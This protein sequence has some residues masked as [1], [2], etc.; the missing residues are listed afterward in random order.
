MNKL[1]INTA[2]DKLFIVLQKEN[3]LFYICNMAKMHHNETMLL[4]IDQL[5]QENNIS[6]KQIDELGVVIGPGS[7]TGIRVG[8]STIKAFRDALN[9]KAKS[10]NNLDYLYALAKEKDNSVD[11]VAILGSKNSY[12]VGKFIH[13][14]LYKY[15]RNL[16]QEEL[17]RVANGSKIGMFVQDE[18]LD[19]VVVEDDAKSMLKCLELSQDETLVPVYYQLSQ[20]ESEKFKRAEVLVEEANEKDLAEICKIEES[21]INVNPLSKQDVLMGL[22]DENYK[23]FKLIFNG[24]IAGFIM[25]QITDEVNIL[26]VAVKKEYRNLGLA[27]KLIEQTENYTKQIGKS[28]VSLEVNYNNITAFLLYEKLGFKQRRVRK[29]YYADGGDCLEMIK[30][31]N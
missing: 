13:N 19:C 28:I 4:L 6:L 24:E 15:E 3:E 22:T 18:N 27:T 14:T 30:E 9:I 2:N 26:S 31:L 16:T 10:I 23:T 12:F 5:L 20:A 25:L 29:S 8:I 1:V 11:T 17:I 7:F 21:S